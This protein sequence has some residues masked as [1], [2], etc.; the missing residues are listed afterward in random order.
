MKPALSENLPRAPVVHPARWDFLTGEIAMIGNRLCSQSF[1]PKD[2]VNVIFPGIR[3]MVNIHGF[4]F[5][6]I[7]EHVLLHKQ[8]PKAVFSKK[9]ILP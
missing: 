8:C 7:Y 6:P 3:K 2:M 9:R 4:F 1:H 5:N